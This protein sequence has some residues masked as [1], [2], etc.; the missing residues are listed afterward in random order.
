VSAD[1]DPHSLGDAPSIGGPSDRPGGVTSSG[2]SIGDA[3]SLVRAPG[4]KGQ[5]PLLP[6]KGYEIQSVLGRGGMGVVYLAR[7]PRLN[8]LVAIKRLLV[9]Q[10]LSDKA[11]ARFLREARV[12]AQLQHP[13]VVSIHELS[14]DEH[15]PFIV[16]EYV[17]GGSLLDLIKKKGK[18]DET[19][20]LEVIKAVCR[21]VAHAHKKGV[22]H[23]DLKPGNVLLT[24]D[25]IPKVA[26]FGLARAADG[27]ELSVVGQALGTLF[28][29]APEQ[30]RD[31]NSVDARADV[32]SIGKTLYH[33]VTGK[34]PETI[35]L[36]KLST[37]LA[38][39][40]EQ[41]LEDDPKERYA[42]VDELLEALERVRPAS[43]GK[44]TGYTASGRHVAV[45]PGECPGCG[46]HN[47]DIAHFCQSCGKSLHKPC[48]QC[49]HENRLGVTF[50]GGC[51]F[52]IKARAEAEAKLALAQTALA[53]LDYEGA[54]S[55][56]REARELDQSFEAAP[57]VLA[58]AGLKASRLKDA[59][60]Q[61]GAFL[62]TDEFD[63]TEWGSAVWALETALELM[64]S[65]G[66]LKA[67]RS[68]LEQKALAG[69]RAQASAHREAGRLAEALKSFAKAAEQE[70]ASG[71]AAAAVEADQVRQ[72]MAKRNEVLS[73]GQQALE[74][75]R[76]AAARA[77][78]Q[79]GLNLF[80]T[81]IIAA[82]LHSKAE[83][84]EQNA[85]DLVAKVPDLQRL[86]KLDLDQALACLGEASQLNSE[87]TQVIALSEELQDLARQRDEL[88]ASGRRALEA[89]EVTQGLEAAHKV[90]ALVPG[91]DKATALRTEAEATSN[92]IAD[93]RKRATA[94][95]GAGRLAETSAALAEWRRLEAVNAGQTRLATDLKLALRGR[96]RR[97]VLVSGA[98]VLLA[99]VATLGIMAK[100]NRDL[101]ARARDR[102][103][104]GDEVGARTAL[105]AARQPVEW[106]VS[107]LEAAAVE[108]DARQ[109]EEDAQCFADA[110]RG[111]TPEAVDRYLGQ[112]SGKRW[113]ADEATRLL[114]H[115]TDQRKILLAR[116]KGAIR[117]LTW[118][119]ALATYEEAARGGAVVGSQLAEVS[120]KIQA[121]D[122]A[123]ISART[124]ASQQAWE[125]AASNYEIALALGANAKRELAGIHGKIQARDGALER[126]RAALQ[127]EAWEKAVNACLIADALGADVTDSLVAA[128]AGAKRRDREAALARAEANKSARHWA[129]AITEYESAGRLGADVA[130]LIRETRK[131][132]ALAAAAEAEL[133]RETRKLQALAAAAEARAHSDWPAAAQAYEEARRQGAH[134][135]DELA[136]AKA[137]L[138]KLKTQREAV[139]RGEAATKRSQWG[140]AVAAYEEALRLGARVE[141][142]LSVARRGVAKHTEL[143]RAGF[144]FLRLEEFSCGGQRH[145][146]EVYRCEAFAKAVRLTEAQTD[147]ACEFVLVP[148]GTFLMG[149]PAN[150]AGRISAEGPQHQV[151]VK[152]FLVARTEVIQAVW[153]GVMG[154]NPAKWK[155]A[156][157]PVNKVSWLDAL[158]FCQKTGLRL[159]SEAEWEYACRAGTRS[160]FSTGDRT[161][162]LKA[163]AWFKW[164]SNFTF[165]AVGTKAPNA[166]GLFD[167]H[168]NVSEY[169]QDA[170]HGNYNGAPSDGSA[171]VGG[172]GAPWDPRT[173]RFHP[174]KWGC[175]TRGG[176]F[177]AEPRTCR[178]AWRIKAGRM[179]RLNTIGFRPSWSLGP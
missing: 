24:E 60:Q 52:N 101:L 21:G 57:P 10:G 148:G 36:H 40:L 94:A 100:Q 69:F 141:S 27:A 114:A 129:D 30:R 144:R 107:R 41:T 5:A 153:Q 123:L 9:S 78:A 22:L 90:E 135:E 1:P 3:P 120:D 19:R 11:V 130:E 32:Y 106:F 149:S 105:A 49:K 131:L 116:A 160:R 124:A 176:N 138:Q 97:R 170:A 175:I 86:G 17:G 20:A 81:D 43:P 63:E 127:Q 13:G 151:T 111:G 121:R 104:A 122:E 76:P 173:A 137:H 44:K 142:E 71:H 38:E 139:S 99:T 46:A 85:R 171:W 128:R 39:V 16:M 54:E 154:S 168:G 115:L 119:E 15:G 164:T 18:L 23:R 162:P 66:E 140:K 14:E 117:T 70:L 147:P 73:K 157:L 67:Q 77:A 56:A 35:K 165:H 34:L 29:M 59:R 8:R 152:P 50:C 64:P 110:K 2:Q 7:Q 178:S 172:G 75:G 95:L 125:E 72:D 25:G 102:A 112:E 48:S 156:K 155:G 161:S 61:L 87:D 150:E 89:G 6:A 28:Y 53:R 146:V 65:D 55:L 82:K 91:D 143:A 88:L 80:P 167:M 179:D 108:A 126:G 51:G 174:G 31:A 103:K 163:V 92:R 159:P 37:G 26:D 177:Q 109:I 136:D 84:A 166:F 47:P 33:L 133:I 68:T 169:C 98:L 118:E 158:S 96:R 93:L 134:V 42:S 74:E 79:V 113:H 62:E 132:Q 4:A 12:V 45:E 145:T 58:D 83:S